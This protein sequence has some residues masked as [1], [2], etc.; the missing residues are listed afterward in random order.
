[1]SPVNV[2]VKPM[3]MA[4]IKA[5]AKDLGI[6]PGSMKKTELIHVIQRAEGFNAC[7]GTSNGQCPFM[8]CCFRKDCLKIKN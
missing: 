4:Q 2:A 6:N 3:T 1:M 8:E 7:Y 5:K